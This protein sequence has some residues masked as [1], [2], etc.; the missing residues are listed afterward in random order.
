MLISAVAA[1]L[2]LAGGLDALQ[3]ATI[4]VAL[5]FLVVLLGLAVALVRDLSRDPAVNPRRTRTRR[6]GLA[7]AVRAARSYEEEDGPPVARYLRR[8]PR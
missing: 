4:L 7:A 1:A 5:P 6:Y 3:Q 2:L 8:R